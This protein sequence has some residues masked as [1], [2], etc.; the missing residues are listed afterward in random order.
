MFPSV[1]ETGRRRFVANGGI[2]RTKFVVLR[3]CPRKHDKK[4]DFIDD[5]YNKCFGSVRF[6]KCLPIDG[7]SCKGK[8]I[9]ELAVIFEVFLLVK[10]YLI[11]KII[12]RKN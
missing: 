4:R 8:G 12:Y 6:V 11:R 7:R 9:G 10:L 3:N 1:L 5:L 2:L